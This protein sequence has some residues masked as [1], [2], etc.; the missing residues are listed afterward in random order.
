MTIPVWNE[1][2]E[3]SNYAVWMT[4]ALGLVFPGNQPFAEVEEG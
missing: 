2:V 1:P 4:I 3:I